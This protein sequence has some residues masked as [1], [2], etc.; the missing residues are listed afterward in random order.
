[1]V[2]LGKVVVSLFIKQGYSIRDARTLLLNTLTMNDL[3]LSI[4]NTLFE[5]E[6]ESPSSSSCK[7]VASPCKSWA[8][9]P[10]YPTDVDLTE[11]C[12]TSSD[13]EFSDE[14]S[15]RSMN[16]MQDVD[17]I[18]ISI[19]DGEDDD[20]EV[21]EIRSSSGDSDTSL[22][23]S[24][25]ANF[26][27]FEDDD[28]DEV[29][30]IRASSG[31]SDTS[32]IVSDEAD[33]HIFEDDDE[34]LEIRASSGDPNTSLI[35]SNDKLESMIYRALAT[36][37]RERLKQVMPDQE[38]QEAGKQHQTKIPL[39]TE[40]GDS[41]EH[42]EEP[43]NSEPKSSRQ[44]NLQEW[45]MYLSKYVSTVP[46]DKEE[47]EDEEQAHEVSYKNVYRRKEPRPHLAFLWTVLCFLALAIVFAQV[48]GIDKSGSSDYKY[49]NRYCFTS[50]EELYDAID[51]FVQ[52]KNPQESA[53]AKQYGHPMSTWC[54]GSI[55][56]FNDAFS[57]QRN[58]ILAGFSEDL[59]DWDTS[60]ATD[61]TS[62]FEGCSNFNG[63]V[64]KWDVSNVH[65]MEN[66]F[67][68]AKSFNGDLSQW[69]VGKVTSMRNLYRG[70]RSYAP[71]TMNDWDVSSV[72]D[73]A[74]MFRGAKAF[75][76]QVDLWDVQNLQF[77]EDMFRNGRQF[78]QNL[79][80]W[81]PASVEN[82][83]MFL[84][85]ARSFSQDL[86]PWR[87][88]LPQNVSVLDMFPETACPIQADASSVQ[89]GTFCFVCAE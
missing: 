36:F 43:G 11:A 27:I 62:M 52:A 42:Q 81:N 55:T 37:Q 25:K 47:E 65:T 17:K 39:K 32:L 82:L 80:S 84:A 49:S 66:M 6:Q 68:K 70:A 29:L 28:D 51:D 79:S 31:D 41:N 7:S 78:N 8:S 45:Q 85:G 58:P 30:E 23:V 57:A 72:I 74:G 16:S 88:R 61:M 12:S 15:D 10:S 35:M 38:R 59:S 87:A 89:D 50:L 13:D 54:V 20:D 3:I 56:N 63:D 22:I 67:R 83:F 4:F 48:A 2:A 53:A 26:H 44:F 33:F 14:S 19:G 21:L 69:R 71:A 5:E 60:S 40:E 24:D 34:V 64:S 9:Y 1:V 75:N 18:D 76:A 86:C 46:I 77:A 73:M